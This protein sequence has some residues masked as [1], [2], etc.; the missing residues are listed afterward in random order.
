MSIR[1][2]GALGIHNIVQALIQAGS[3]VAALRGQARSAFIEIG[4]KELVPIEIDYKVRKEMHGNEPDMQ[5]LG[6]DSDM[7]GDVFVELK[8]ISDHP[9][10]EGIPVSLKQLRMAYSGVPIMVVAFRVRDESM[11]WARDNF[12]SD[13]PAECL[14]SLK[15]LSSIAHGNATSYKLLSDTTSIIRKAADLCEHCGLDVKQLT[16]LVVY[17]LRHIVQVLLAGQENGAFKSRAIT[18]TL[19]MRPCADSIDPFDIAI[20]SALYTNFSAPN[21]VVLKFDAV[22]REQ[23][24]TPLA[25]AILGEI[26]LAM[27]WAAEIA[28]TS[29]TPEVVS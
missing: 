22:S 29:T 15:N 21:T 20:A 14:R 28:T 24:E 18:R 26:S 23:L 6:D 17:D 3:F 8:T 13:E 25:R 5:R 7:L 10:K 4:F 12:D 11:S 16:P 9:S 27:K 1:N 2:C 19:T